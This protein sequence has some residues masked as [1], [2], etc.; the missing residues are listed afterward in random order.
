VVDYLNAKVFVESFDL[1]EVS[2]IIGLK[3]LRPKGNGME[4]RDIQIEIREMAIDDLPE[5]MK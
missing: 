1:L 2:K 4:N 3:C 5:L